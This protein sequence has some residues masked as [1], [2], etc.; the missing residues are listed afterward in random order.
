MGPMQL[1]LAVRSEKG[2]TMP[3][4]EFHPDLRGAKFL[5]RHVLRRP[6]WLK[7]MRML[8]RLSSPGAR[9]DASLVPVDEHV[10]V[11]V[12]RPA[13]PGTDRPALL[14]ILSRRSRR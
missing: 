14:W 3:E 4:P 6:R 2:T 1:E 10:S 5:P 13:T 8:V 11:R 7:P 9:A 12:F